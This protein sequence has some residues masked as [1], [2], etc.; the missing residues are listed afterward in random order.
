MTATI[1]NIYILYTSKGVYTAF[2][3][4]TGH[5]SHAHVL[6]CMH[7]Y[8]YTMQIFNFIY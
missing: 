2:C 5:Y 1:L 8:N 6:F 4:H 7:A 3:M